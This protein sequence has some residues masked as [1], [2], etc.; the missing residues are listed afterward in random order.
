[1]PEDTTGRKQVTFKTG[2][3]LGTRATFTHEGQL[4]IAYPAPKSAAIVATLDR[5][6]GVISGIADDAVRSI[7]GH[8]G[9]AELA[10][11]AARVLSRAQLA[12]DL[13]TEKVKA[14]TQ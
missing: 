4:W 1:M 13:A 2:L 14:V 12:D 7:N 10:A 8:P 5:M 6:L 11:F 3:P 9:N